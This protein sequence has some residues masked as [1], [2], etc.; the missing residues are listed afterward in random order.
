LLTV[1]KKNDCVYDFALV[2]SPGDGFARA[3]TAYDGVLGSFATIE[4]P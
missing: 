1:M 3:R 2:A 4:A